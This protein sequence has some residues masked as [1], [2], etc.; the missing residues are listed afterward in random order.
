[1]VDPKDELNSPYSFVKNNP[2]KL[3]DPDGREVSV[4]QQLLSNEAFHQW[5]DNS[6]AF[7]QLVGLFGKGGPLDKYTRIEINDFSGVGGQAEIRYNSVALH[8]FTHG[9]SWR[10][11]PGGSYT[12]K[13]VLNPN[14]W[15]KNPRPTG[16]HEIDH[17]MYSAMII[18]Q[19]KNGEEVKLLIGYKQDEDA[20]RNTGT[21]LTSKEFLPEILKQLGLE[22]LKL[23]DANLDQMVKE[24]AVQTHDNRSFLGKMWDSV[25]DLFSN[26]E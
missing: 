18:L 16:D 25:K 12:A 26:E 1:M 19:A 23:P 7:K 2:I 9:E 8:P 5:A 10:V 24:G 21:D 22:D 11:D 4:S 14:N 15:N 3:V 20:V 13:V 6:L 17:V